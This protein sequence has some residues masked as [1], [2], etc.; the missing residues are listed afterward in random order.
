MNF[1]KIIKP[2]ILIFS[3]IFLA[4]AFLAFLYG[5][6][7]PNAGDPYI[8]NYETFHLDTDWV[9]TIE[10]E[11]EAQPAMVDMGITRSD[12]M[13]KT[14]YLKHTLPETIE[15]G[16]VVCV[17]S[18]MNDLYIYVDGNISSVYTTKNYSD[19]DFDL[20]SA[21]VFCDI[22]GEDAGKEITLK[23]Y[24]KATGN[25]NP[26]LYGFSGNI[27]YELHESAQPIVFTGSTLMIIGGLVIL[28]FLFLGMSSKAMVYLLYI[29]VL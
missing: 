26:V 13:G 27:F 4:V 21:Y 20:P 25:L 16:M 17:R 8:G 22:S 11:N 24:M 5:K 23:M 14:I 2:L 28:A 12:L 18:S 9:L 1:N 15:N 19:R 10:G 29:G 3:S 6:L 7:I